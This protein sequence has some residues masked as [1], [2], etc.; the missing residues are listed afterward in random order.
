MMKDRKRRAR[1]EGEDGG[2]DGRRDVRME[3]LKPG[4]SYLVVVFQ[5]YAHNPFHTLCL[6][7]A[8][9]EVQQV[10]Q[11]I[12]GVGGLTQVNMQSCRLTRLG[13]TELL[14]W[15]LLLGKLLIN[16]DNLIKTF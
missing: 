8:A 11:G 10:L 4:L 12:S 9:G 2:R 16:I 5:Q 14:G 3:R 7:G 15:S 1:T 13:Q 6:H